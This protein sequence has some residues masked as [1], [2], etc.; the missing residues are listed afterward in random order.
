M[1]ELRDRMYQVC[2][3][4]VHTVVNTTVSGN[5]VQNA[6]GGIFNDSYSSVVAINTTVS[7]NSAR[8]GGGIFNSPVGSV[9]ATNTTISGNTAQQGG[10]GIYNG[11]IGATG[12]NTNFFLK[13]SL[14]A[15]N[16]LAG[17]CVNENQASVLSAGYN[18]SDDSSCVAFL[19]NTGDE[20]AISAGLDPNGLQNNGGPT[21]T[22]AL[23]P[24]SLAVDAIPVSACTDV[25]GNSLTTDQRGITRPQG[26]ACDIGALELAQGNSGNNPPNYAAA[27]QPPIN[28]NGSSVFKVNMGSLI[29]KF[30]L[31]TNG[32]LTCQ[33]PPATISLARIAGGTIGTMS[34]STYSIPSDKGSNFR[35]DT[36]TCQYI[37]NIGANSLGVGTYRVQILIDEVQV[38]T[39][40]FGLH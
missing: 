14:L 37:Y 10:G 6:G 22:I 31:A 34:V 27:I 19:T 15:N 38:G 12:E 9:T 18:L 40:T 23:L 17:N 13:N 39:A 2:L 33:M 5:A 21:Q 3:M 30:T 20:N 24:T 28:A 35:I 1:T 36:T 32:V 29:V 16:G 4:L 26:S 25:S 8:T 7:G 11:L